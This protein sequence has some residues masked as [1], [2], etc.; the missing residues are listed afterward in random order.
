MQ[1]LLRII[2]AEK[3]LNFICLMQDEKVNFYLYNI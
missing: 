2:T 3:S 1:L